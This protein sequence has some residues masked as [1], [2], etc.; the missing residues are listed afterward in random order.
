[1][2]L[3]GLIGY[4]L[5]HSFSEGYFAEKFRKEGIE[6]ARYKNFPIKNIDELPGLINQHP[7]LSGLNV[8]IPYK[9]AVIPYLNQL[10]PDAREI[11][12]V[13][14][15]RIERQSSITGST[16][17]KEKADIVNN[18]SV[19]N[20][21][22]DTK[23]GDTKWYHS[24]SKEGNYFLTGYNTDLYGFETSLFPLLK[25]FHQKA[26]VL[27]TGGAS[28][29]VVYA[30]KR[31]DIEYRLVSRKPSAEQVLAYEQITKQ[32]VNN[33]QIIINTSPLG[34]YPDVDKCPDLPYEHLSEEHILYDLIYNPAETLFLQ[35]GKAK[36]SIIK[37]GLEM[38]ELQAEKS[39]EIWNRE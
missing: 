17:Q 21:N 29:A 2:P 15:I 30:L 38:L 37:N 34:M 12:A 8:T 20:R 1:M 10:D 35:K 19:S 26:L 6:D 18:G 14:T 3:Y 28:K 5:S 11:G 7:E 23:N 16:Y 25:P 27:G 31:M 24:G 4:P 39:W 13:N 36:G 33:H 9:E 32:V 22:P